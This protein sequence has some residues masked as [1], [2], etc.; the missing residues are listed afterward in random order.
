MKKALV[1]IGIF[2]VAMICITYIMLKDNTVQKTLPVIN[3]TDL[4]QEMVD[5]SKYGIGQGHLIGDFSFTNQDGKTI[6]QDDVKNKVYVVEYFFTTCK[7]ICPIMNQNMQKVHEAFKDNEQFKILSFT[8]DPENDTPQQLKSY[9]EAHQTGKNWHFLTGKKEDLYHLA[10]TSY[11]VLKP[12]EAENQGDVGSD[13]IHTNNF[14]LIDQQKRIRAYYDGTNPK[15]ID[16]LIKDVK[17]LLSE[18]L[19]F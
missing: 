14:V 8:V 13:F 11:F 7:T 10:R 19:T 2:S 16:K 12:A 17:Q 9:A 4:N 1:F 6:T 18:K 15:E 3:P 5:S